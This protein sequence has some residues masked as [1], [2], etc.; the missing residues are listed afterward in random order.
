ML[1][2]SYRKTLLLVS[3]CL[4]TFGFA[5]ALPISY[6]AEN[7]LLSTGKWVKVK[8][9]ETGMQEITLDRLRELGFDD[10]MNVAVYGYSGIELSTYEFSRKMPDDLPAV[11]TAIYGDKLVFYGVAADVPV[12]YRASSG[13]DKTVVM[14]NRNLNN[15]CSYY[16]LTDSQP[17]VNVAVSSVAEVSGQDVVTTAHG[18]LWKNFTDQHPGEMGNF[19][20][21]E[22]FAESKQIAYDLFMPG[23]IPDGADALKP[24]YPVCSF[25]VGMKAQ[26]SRIKLSINGDKGTTFTVTGY[27]NDPGHVNYRYG[28]GDYYFQNAVKSD[29]DHYQLTAE[30]SAQTEAALAT[31]SQAA[32]EFYAISYPRTTDLSAGGQQRFCFPSLGK[33][34]TV[35]LSNAVDG[36]RV[37][38]VTPGS[39]PRE[40][41]L[42][43]GDIAG[44]RVFVSDKAYSTGS[45]KD[46]KSTLQTIA[47]DPAEQLF[48]VEV[49]G[50]VANQNYHALPVP[51]ML[52]VATPATYDQALALADFHKEYTGV[53]VCV[54]S[55]PAVCNEFASGVAHPMA[56]RRM[57]KMLYDRDPAKLKA[58][59][60]IGRAFSDNT[61]STKSMSD[62]YFDN[63][64]IP[65]F[66]CDDTAT[67][68]EQPK[69]YSTDLLYGM[70]TDNFKYDRST[71][72]KN[73]LM[74]CNLDINIGR[75]PATSN[76]EVGDY[77]KKARR[78]LDS[79]FAKASYNR[80]A[81]TSDIG[82]EN[83]HLEQ[84]LHIREVVKM[85][86]PST[87]TDMQAL[88]IYGKDGK[89][90]TQLRRRFEQ[91]LS[92]GVANWFYLG[93]S[94]N[95][96]LIAANDFWSM[97]IN[98]DM[99]IECPPFVVM[100]T[101]QSLAMD[102][103]KT[104]LQIDMLLNADGGMIAGVGPSRPAYAQYNVH[105]VDIMARSYYV[106][107][108]GDTFGDIFRSAHNLY[109]E[110][111]E[112]IAEGLEGHAGVAV[113]MMCYNFAGDPMM[114]AQIPDHAVRLT[115]INGVNTR[116]VQL[117][118]LT[119]HH[120]AGDVYG[121]DGWV[122][123]TFNGEL[124]MTIYDGLH[125][126]DTSSNADIANPLRQVDIDETILQEVKM[127]VVNGHF[128][129]K[130]T[131]ALPA[132]TGRGNRVTLYAVSDD[133]ER[134]AKGN[135]DGLEITQ[136]INDDI[137]TAAPIITS[138]YAGDQN[139]QSN[140]S[141]PGVFTLYATI[142]ADPLPLLGAGS[143]R[144]GGSVSLIVDDSHKMNAVDSYLDVAPD[145]SAT[146][147][148]PVT[149]LSDG[150]HDLK[151]RVVNVAGESDERSIT[152]NVVNVAQ[153]STVTDALMARHEAVISLDHQLADEPAGRL[154]IKDTAGNTVFSQENVEFPYTWDLKD[155]R[156][157]DVADGVYTANVFFRAGRHY[158]G[159]EP[160]S[161]VV[162]R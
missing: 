37:W 3:L 49:I 141:L 64:Y 63:T 76:A 97:P 73:H 90:N 85:F 66:Q 121:P 21:G 119:E 16:F 116:A 126:A 140:V 115:S 125:T 31:L 60:I 149:G 54:V 138:M 30:A 14:L 113:N 13:S 132:Y 157:E 4:L 67:A 53:E 44:D 75:I 156:G 130:F 70:L 45:I 96:Q 56:I 10:P 114:P 69:A 74:R 47:F 48:E 80:M 7:S 51:E 87:M 81:I 5:A 65:M 133:L 61:G 108:P 146:L 84:A 89:S 92:K 17:R 137:P 162:G 32:I 139:A 158:G 28:S 12:E 42:K 112:E 11:P 20:F 155:S 94:M 57:V 26:S 77:L 129:G 159:S 8:V 99:Y 34:Q 50:D 102:Q 160:V 143:D 24:E 109:V 83:L 131:L 153:A 55:Y 135:Y 161:I 148:Y 120:V 40:M 38:D 104:T 123:K 151:L 1:S 107:R 91:Q 136:H 68:G 62:E 127:Q 15:T 95:G 101:C 147:R 46:G 78:F 142:E 111:P 103:I 152:V 154:V 88:S 100:G 39:T 122:D 43:T 58:L 150:T 93:H 128:D 19:L 41:R 52:V 6:Y 134:G 82:D 72:Q 23:F 86:S 35:K 79:K 36:L 18:L 117:P 59:L 105:L 29:D 9:T 110:F 98:R 118:P 2:Q 106:A 22:N 33:G 144:L 145:G 25:G 71:Q 124:T 27:G